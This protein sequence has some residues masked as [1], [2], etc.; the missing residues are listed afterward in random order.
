MRKSW[1]GGLE[2]GSEGECGGGERLESVGVGVGGRMERVGLEGGREDGESVWGWREDGESGGWREDGDS[3][4]GGGERL[5]GGRVQRVW[6]G[7][8]HG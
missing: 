6:G 3:V 5:E 8:V 2:G 4:C 7:R 1:G